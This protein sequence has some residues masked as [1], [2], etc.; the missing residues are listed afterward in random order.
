MKPGIDLT[1]DAMARS[2]KFPVAELEKGR[3]RELDHLTTF[4][5]FD[6]TSELLRGYRMQDMV[7]VD[8][9]R[10]DK[11]PLRLYVRLFKA[12]QQRD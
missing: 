6:E 5:A 3:A 1:N 11:V 12:E 2:G 7:W 8:E 10:G 9:W 4:D